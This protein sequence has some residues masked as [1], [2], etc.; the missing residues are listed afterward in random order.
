MN[1]PLNY[2]A[3]FL[4]LAHLVGILLY[5]F[6][7]YKSRILDYFFSLL[8]AVGMSEGLKFLLDKPR[9]VLDLEGGSFPSTHAALAFNALFFVLLACH[10]LSKHQN[11]EGRWFQILNYFG[12]MTKS[13]FLILIS[14]T[15]ISVGILRIVTGAHYIEDVLAGILVGFL[16][17]GVFRY[18]DVSARRLK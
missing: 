14:T 15:A 9:P 3:D 6:L 4:V 16:A 11:R 18:Y 5:I 8:L 12:N 2:L 7:N 1:N 17:A 10:T 13:K